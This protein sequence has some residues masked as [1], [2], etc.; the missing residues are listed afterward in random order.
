MSET[1]SAFGVGAATIT[2]KVTATTGVNRVVF[3]LASI[4]LT[5]GFYKLEIDLPNWFSKPFANLGEATYGVYLLHPVVYM[6]V[7]KVVHQPVLC[8][9]VTSVATII[10]ANISY[11]VYEKPFIKIGKKSTTFEVKKI[12]QVS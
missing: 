4:A 10:A 11:R 2:Q 7:N 3:A 12:E 1:Q 6:F 9:I 5:L 8:I